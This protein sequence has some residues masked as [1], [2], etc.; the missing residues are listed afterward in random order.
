M[1]AAAESTPDDPYHTLPEAQ[2]APQE[3]RQENQ[4]L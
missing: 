3:E 2:P 1:L 4:P